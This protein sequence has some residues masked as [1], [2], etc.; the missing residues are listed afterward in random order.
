MIQLQ[1]N[2]TKKKQVK[3]SRINPKNINNSQVW[4]FTMK[5]N[6]K[7]FQI[8]THRGGASMPTGCGGREISRGVVACFGQSWFKFSM[9]FNYSQYPPHSLSWTWRAPSWRIGGRLHARCWN[10]GGWG[11]NDYYM[12]PGGGGWNRTIYEKKKKKKKK[13]KSTLLAEHPYTRAD[14]SVDLTIEKYIEVTVCKKYKAGDCK[15]KQ[16]LIKSRKKT[17][18]KMGKAFS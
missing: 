4:G 7:S 18:L 6:D 13:P 9:C 5:W 10:T 12:I 8:T 1:T 11:Y 16:N 15:Q 17:A 2:E 14:T 3:Q